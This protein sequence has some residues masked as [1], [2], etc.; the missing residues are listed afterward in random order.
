M[1]RAAATYSNKTRTVWPGRT[2]P[3][4]DRPARKPAGEKRKAGW[5]PLAVPIL[6][7]LMVC[8]TV[9]Y[10]AYSE[11]SRERTEFE[12]LGQQVD[13]VTSENLSLQEEIHYLKTDPE[14]IR[15]EAQKLGILPRVQKVPVPGGK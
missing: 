8:A 15:R 5:V 11:L 13:A 12:T 6:M 3:T 7:T 9:N 1:K 4:A 10:R 2:A 14:T